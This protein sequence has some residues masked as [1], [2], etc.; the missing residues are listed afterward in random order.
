MRMAAERWS[1]DGTEGN[2]VARALM[3]FEW[4]LKELSQVVTDTGINLLSGDYQ[5]TFLPRKNSL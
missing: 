3:N 1:G 2:G 4:Q 5:F